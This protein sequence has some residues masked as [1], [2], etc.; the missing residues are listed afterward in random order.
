MPKDP[1]DFNRFV[2]GNLD[3]FGLWN[4]ALSS[5]AITTLYNSGFPIN[6]TVNTGNY[7]AGD[8]LGLWWRCGESGDSNTPDGINDRS[9]F[10]NSNPGTMT[11]MEDSDIDTVDFAGA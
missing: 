2:I 10:G 11:A 7:M 8:N 4:T 1:S 9:A 5:D 6:L 3:E